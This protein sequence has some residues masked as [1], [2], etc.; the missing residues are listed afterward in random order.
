MVNNTALIVFA[1]MAALGVTAATLVVPQAQ[2]VV[3]VR[4]HPTCQS[5]PGYSHG[6]PP[7]R[8]GQ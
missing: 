8:C 1:I 4:L 7:H 5:N 2:A 3:P 6:E